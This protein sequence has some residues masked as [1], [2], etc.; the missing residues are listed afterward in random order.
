LSLKWR[1]QRKSSGRRRHSRSFGYFQFELGNTVERV[2]WMLCSWNS[3]VIAGVCTVFLW[4]LCR[5]WYSLFIWKPDVIGQHD[6][7]NGACA[8]AQENVSRVPYYCYCRD[9]SSTS[10]NTFL[11]FLYQKG[12]SCVTI[13]HYPVFGY[14]LVFNFLHS[15][16]SRW[17]QENIFRNI[18]LSGN[19]ENNCFK[20]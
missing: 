18:Y 9:D 15:I 13:R 5:I 3:F 19:L 8:A 14:D 7:F 11:C 10:S 6:V 2:H 4:K 16:R 12:R 1:R 17:S 20:F